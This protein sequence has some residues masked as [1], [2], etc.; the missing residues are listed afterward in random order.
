MF[1]GA[2]GTRYNNTQII[3]DRYSDTG[4]HGVTGWRE[5]H[6]Q[7]LSGQER[8]LDVR[9]QTYSTQR[10]CRMPVS[11]HLP[12]LLL[13]LPSSSSSFTHPPLHPALQDTKH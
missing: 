6:T 13:P 3:G 2:E 10:R 1:L 11:Y 9:K 4:S 5:T 8:A 7:Y 12:F